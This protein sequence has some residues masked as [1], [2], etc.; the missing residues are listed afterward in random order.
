[1][2]GRENALRIFIFDAVWALIQLFGHEKNQWLSND[3]NK[4]QPPFRELP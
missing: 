1:M 3:N 2:R 4:K